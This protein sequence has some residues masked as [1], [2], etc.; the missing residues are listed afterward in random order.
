MSK[1]S[2]YDIIARQPFLEKMY[3]HRKPT[4]WM[5]APT[6][7]MSDGTN[8]SKVSFLSIYYAKHA[9]ILSHNLFV[10]ILPPHLRPASLFPH[11]NIG[12]TPELSSASAALTSLVSQMSNLLDLALWGDRENWLCLKIVRARARCWSNHDLGRPL[13]FRE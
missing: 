3:K 4:F 9:P 10:C 2:K 1:Y 5:L 6:Q 11:I 12:S 8:V 13:V 7:H